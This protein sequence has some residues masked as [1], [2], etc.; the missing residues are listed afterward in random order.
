MPS[1]RIGIL[2]LAFLGAGCASAEIRK[3][4][5]RSDYDA[6]KWE[7][8]RKQQYADSLRGLRFYRSRPYVNV[9][10]SSGRS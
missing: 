7:S 2:T 3:V 4:P 9:G 5:K 6:K 8:E 10:D 1:K